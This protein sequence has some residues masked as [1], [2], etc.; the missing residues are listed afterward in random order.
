MTDY[1]TMRVVVGLIVVGLLFIAGI[2]WWNTE[3][4]YPMITA[5]VIIGFIALVIIAWPK[6][7]PPPSTPVRRANR[8]IEVADSLW[9]YTL[10]G[11]E[12]FATY[13]G[14]LTHSQ[15]CTNNLCQ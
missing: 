5:F 11:H 15:S 12:Y 1:L 2:L 8:P 14:G 7:M 9:K 10:E 13:S 3:T 6:L 4:G